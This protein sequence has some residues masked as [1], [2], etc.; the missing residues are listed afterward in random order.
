MLDFSA[1][2]CLGA[3]RFGHVVK[4][5]Y[6]SVEAKSGVTAPQKINRVPYINLKN[7]LIALSP[8]KN[9]KN[10]PTSLH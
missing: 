2:S 6:L 1:L 10:N 3:T 9:P 4:I 7:L 5:G 8:E